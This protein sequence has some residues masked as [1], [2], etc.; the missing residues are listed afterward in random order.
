[1][2]FYKYFKVWL[3]VMHRGLCW[4]LQKRVCPPNGR[5]SSAQSFIRVDLGNSGAF[6]RGGGEWTL[7]TT[8]IKFKKWPV[9]LKQRRTWAA[10]KVKQPCDFFLLSKIVFKIPVWQWSIFNII[11]W[12][13]ILKTVTVSFN[14]GVEKQKLLLRVSYKSSSKPQ[15]YLKLYVL[16]FT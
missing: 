4:R 6:C 15:F 14:F 11:S 1:M 2:C 13:F 5:E 9:F 7:H 12:V 3:V 10:S 8:W 16:F